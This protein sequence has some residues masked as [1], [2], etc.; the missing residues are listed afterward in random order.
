M[1]KRLPLIVAGGAILLCILVLL[2]F[3]MPRFSAVSAAQKELD[4]LKATEDTLRAEV[5]HL[6][7][8]R[9]Q[10][11][12]TQR[13]L[14]KNNTLI[15]P[16]ADKP[17]LIRQL[18]FVADK[19]GVD[20]SSIQPSGAAPSA[21]GTFTTLPIQVTVTGTFFQEDEF[22]FRL[23]RLQRAMKVTDVG[24]T[25]SAWPILSMNLTAEA[26]TT[27]T[28]VGPGS[29]PGHQGVEPVIPTAAPS[30]SPA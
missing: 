22:L 19:T 18:Q 13:Q 29:E 9:T 23:E 2:I 27:D 26:F 14:D 17:G 5:S 10:S 4:V 12:A 25:A 8:L 6:E 15:P 3:V 11:G 1:N 16:Q 24:I 20:L 30:P 7:E 21:T 28:S